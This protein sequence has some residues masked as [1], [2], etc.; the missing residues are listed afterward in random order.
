MRSALIILTMMASMKLLLAQENVPKSPKNIVFII[1][2]GMGLSQVSASLYSHT[3]KSVF[4]SFPIIG[5]QKTHAS[6]NLITDS[7]A[8]ATAMA[9]GCKTFLGALGLC[10]DSTRCKTILEHARDRNLAT[11][12]VATSTIVHATPAAFVSHRVARYG[13]EPIALDVAVSHLD[14]CVSLS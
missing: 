13:Y 14:L 3:K 7:A 5:F 2:D 4:E 10:A 9:C 11:G 1:G 8:G 6:N 12:L